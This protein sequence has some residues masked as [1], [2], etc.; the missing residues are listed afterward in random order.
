MAGAL[1]HVS[2][3][4][5]L[6]D[7]QR[8]R[9]LETY[10]RR[11][12]GMPFPPVRY[13]TPVPWLA[14]ALVDL[15]PEFGLLVHLDL[16]QMDLLTLV[17]SQENSCRFCYAAIRMLLWAQG[18]SEARIQR[19]EQRLSGGELE[20]KTAAVVAFGRRQ[21]RVGPPG[22]QEARQSLAVRR[23]RPCRARHARRDPGL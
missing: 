7:P 5:C 18:M 17:V 11:K 20:P 12:M 21:S 3:E 14:R 16:A 13:F 9:A 4:S 2:W 19:I 10:A 1:A 15:H 22:A 23:C 8:D 6:I